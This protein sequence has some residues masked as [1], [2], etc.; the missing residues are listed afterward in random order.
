MN[1]V[2]LGAE[3]L[4]D[5]DRARGDADP[6]SATE[7]NAA[8]LDRELLWSIGFFAGP[9]LPIGLACS[10]AVWP[11]GN[12]S[13]FTVGAIWL[14]PRLSSGESAVCRLELSRIAGPDGDASRLHRP[15]SYCFAMVCCDGPAVS[16][17]L[18]QSRGPNSYDPFVHV[19]VACACRSH[20]ITPIEYLY[21]TAAD[22]DCRPNQ[23]ASF[24]DVSLPR[25]IRMDAAGNMAGQLHDAAKQHLS[26]KSSRF[27]GGLTCAVR[28]RIRGVLGM[29]RSTAA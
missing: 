23:L 5:A 15:A 6:P 20:R 12:R 2:L 9:R 25:G 26:G 27:F 29:P 4:R 8:E 10:E 13:V 14:S 7:P 16:L 19:A 3:S 17:I 11:V 18:G 1:L 24:N 22:P 21:R 28:P